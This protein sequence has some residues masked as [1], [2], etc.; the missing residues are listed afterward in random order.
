MHHAKSDSIILEEQKKALLEKITN[1]KEEVQTQATIIRRQSIE[2][3]A[4]PIKEPSPSPSPQ[5]PP[6]PVM[7]E[8][9]P[10]I[11][12]EIESKLQTRISQQLE[13][14]W[15]DKINQERTRA[16][17]AIEETSK[18]SREMQKRILAEEQ[19][20]AQLNRKVQTL[21]AELERAIQSK[22]ALLNSFSAEMERWRE[23][24]RL[25]KN[26]RS[27]A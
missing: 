9:P 20:I 11:I 1:M 27:V 3:Q 14:E 18:Q 17:S 10:E 13:Q 2:M 26:G 7:V 23:A 6:Q 24:I 4:V 12:R 5:P 15:I 16:E 19:Q 21:E 8:P 25:A 22:S